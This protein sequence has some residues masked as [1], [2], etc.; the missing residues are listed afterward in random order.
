L[1]L[2]ALG[3]VWKTFRQ[4]TNGGTVVLTRAHSNRP[5]TRPLVDIGV[6]RPYNLMLKNQPGDLST[7]RLGGL[8]RATLSCLG[9]LSVVLA[10]GPVFPLAA[11]GATA[12]PAGSNRGT[13]ACGDR[14]LPSQIRGSPPAE[15]R[16]PIA[17]PVDMR[18]DTTSRPM[19]RDPRGD[20][21]L[22]FIPGFRD[23]VRMASRRAGRCA[24]IRRS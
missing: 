23:T 12:I 22:V 14:V 18:A 2:P 20:T 6:S 10:A 15:P 11:R 7:S 3:T 16:L 1:I 21:L 8:M 19:P 17:R 4:A 5:L 24:A 9:P 13:P